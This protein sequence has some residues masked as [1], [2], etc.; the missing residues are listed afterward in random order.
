MAYNVVMWVVV[1]IEALTCELPA[2]RGVAAAPAT[3]PAPFVVVARQA[4][5]LEPFTCST[6]A[7]ASRPST[8]ST[9]S[10]DVWG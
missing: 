9:P 6:D 3:A 10:S 7:T 2:R 8:R 5:E 4:E 1:A